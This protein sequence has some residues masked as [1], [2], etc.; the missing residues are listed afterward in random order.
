CRPRKN[1][2]RTTVHID[3]AQLKFGADLRFVRPLDE[4]S[5]LVVKLLLCEYLGRVEQR[6]VGLLIHE[7][8]LGT[9]HKLAGQVCNERFYQWEHDTATLGI[10]RYTR[11][12]VEKAIGLLRLLGI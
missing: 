10:D 12:K 2:D 5:V 8:L 9:R 1:L 11:E 3:C 4:V 6:L 7:R